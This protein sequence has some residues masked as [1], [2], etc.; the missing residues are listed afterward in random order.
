LPS[1]LILTSPPR[2]S[3][4][5]LPR[6]LLR[7]FSFRRWLYGPISCP[8]FLLIGFGSL[9]GTFLAVCIGSLSRVEFYVFSYW[10]IS[11]LIS[12]SLSTSVSL[13][14]SRLVFLSNTV[15]SR[16]LIFLGLLLRL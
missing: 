13:S 1:F 16:T 9:P 2:S 10:I 3:A 8:S 7:P 11:T 6:F 15:I 4:L 5:T 14:L 12:S